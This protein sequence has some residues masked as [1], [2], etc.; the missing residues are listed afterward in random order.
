M[1]FNNIFIAMLTLFILSTIEGWPNYMYE[2]IDGYEDGPNKD[3]NQW[4]IF[5]F[6]VFILI[7]SMFL[8]N[9]FIGVIFLNYHIAEKKAKN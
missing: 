3:S 9:L 8:L 4:V 5:Y 1:N 7:G 6:V 2:F